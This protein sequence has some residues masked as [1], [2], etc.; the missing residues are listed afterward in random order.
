MSIP[1]NPAL[2]SFLSPTASHFPPTSRYAAVPTA[3]LTLP[4]GTTA[5]Y[6][7]RRFLPQPGGFAV[8]S[9]HLVIQGERLDN[10]AARYFGNPELFWR[11]CDANGAM[12]PAA[13]ERLG[14]VLRITLPEGVPGPTNA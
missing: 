11:I 14:S 8:L 13:L 6:L 4:D 3:Q 5:R 1:P 10:I 12:R 7:L 9:E 2:Q